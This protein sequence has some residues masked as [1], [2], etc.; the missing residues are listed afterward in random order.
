M[1]Q[2]LYFHSYIFVVAQQHYIVLKIKSYVGRLS[3]TCDEP[4]YE[5]KS[6]HKHAVSCW[7]G[8]ILCILLLLI[9]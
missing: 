2:T 4:R 7:R 3:W 5:W 6:S 9:D 1:I 8:F